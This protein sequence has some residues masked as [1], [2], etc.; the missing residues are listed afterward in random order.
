MTQRSGMTFHTVDV[1]KYLIRF[2]DGTDSHTPDM[3]AWQLK[4]KHQD[5]VS[6][7]DTRRVSELG[8]DRMEMEVH[9]TTVA[10]VADLI[11]VAGMEASQ[12][13]TLLQNAFRSVAIQ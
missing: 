8:G 13:W 12:G 9:L 5:K 6:F 4:Q 2:A 7:V 10:D 3:I 1:N 11:H